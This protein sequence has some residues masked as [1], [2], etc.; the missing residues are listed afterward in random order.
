[1]S[2]YKIPNGF[3]LIIKTIEQLK[4]PEHIKLEQW[5]N[6]KLACIVQETEENFS[7][8]KMIVSL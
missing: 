1:M 7:E 3:F 8:K 4:L 5:L 2:L 6:F